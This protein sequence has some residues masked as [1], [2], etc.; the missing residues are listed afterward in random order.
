MREITFAM[1]LL[2]NLI[3]Y[4]EYKKLTENSELLNTVE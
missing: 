2:N 1:L 3:T 4:E